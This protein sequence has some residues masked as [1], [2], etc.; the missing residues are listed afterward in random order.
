MVNAATSG[1]WCAPSFRGQKFLC[2]GPSQTSD[3]CISSSGCSCV[4][5]IS[6]FNKL[7]SI[8][9]SFPEFLQFDHTQGGGYW[10]LWSVVCW[11]E[12]GDNL[13]LQLGS[14]VQQ[15]APGGQSFETESLTCAVWCYLWVDGV[16]SELNC[17][18]PRWYC[19]KLLGEEP[20]IWWPEMKCF[21]W[22][23]KGESSGRN[24][25]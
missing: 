8:R 7:V 18:T 6:S 22:V 10:N 13:G 20:H 17:R 25:Q 24:I 5:F 16:R 21:V 1:G 4:S 15:G 23:S 9:K 19:R 11:S 14:E 3:L 2:W 12:A